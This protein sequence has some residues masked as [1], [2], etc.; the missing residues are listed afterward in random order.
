MVYDE[1]LFIIITLK[2]IL[3]F[4]FKNVYWNPRLGTEHERIV[5]LLQPNDVVYDCFAGVG[6]FS[7]PAISK[8]KCFTVLA[9]D[10]NPNSFRSLTENY[11]TNNRSKLKKKELEDRKEH[12]KKNPPPKLIFENSIT[13]FRFDI[14]QPFA[15]FNLGN[16]NVFKF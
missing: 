4:I 14:N 1:L 13:K 6:P 16:K 2:L 15:A 11:T 9:N 10:L 7:I 5:N 8:R 12:I 3:F